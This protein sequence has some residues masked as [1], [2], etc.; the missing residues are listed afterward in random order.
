MFDWSG[1]L[2]DDHWP[3]FHA[4]QKVI[5]DLSGHKIT[6]P[7]YRKHFTIPVHPFYRRYGIKS[8]FK[9]IDQYY[10]D[11]YRNYI[12]HGKLF[13]GVKDCLKYLKKQ[14]IKVSIFS[15]V[16]PDMIEDLVKKFGLGPYIDYIQGCVYNKTKEMPGHLKK[17]RSKAEHTLYVGDMDHDVEAANKNKVMSGA[18][19]SGYHGLE[20]LMDE[21]PR[22][23]WSH[24]QD[25]LPFFKS[26]VQ[27]SQK[28]QAKDY[29]VST[30]GSLI[31]NPD[32]EMLLVLTHKWDYTYGIPGGKIEKGEKAEDAAVREIYEETGLKTKIK[33][34]L[35]VQDCIHSKEFYVPKSHFLLFNYL[36]TTRQKK[37]KLNDEALSYVWVK[38]E[39]ALNLN[40]NEPTRKLIDTYLAE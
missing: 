35:T 23:L 16:H 24:P 26:A 21:K 19:A 12:H 20:R 14:K 36:A 37:V 6:F 18:V 34:L 8:S 17:M 29:P 27:S 32:Q 31:M 11:T 9:K 33:K 10:F 4:T 1:T 2:Y 39:K 25:W 5:K 40:L 3:S 28:K 13:E 15:T 30:S 22:F 7:E 38:P